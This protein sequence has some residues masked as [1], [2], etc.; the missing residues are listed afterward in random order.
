MFPIKVVTE[1]QEQMVAFHWGHFQIH[2]LPQ[3]FDSYSKFP[4][5]PFY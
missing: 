2:L 4:K 3:H 5:D 1:D